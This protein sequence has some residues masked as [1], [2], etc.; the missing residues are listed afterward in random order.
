MKERFDL[1]CLP[2]SG[3]HGAS[4]RYRLFQYLPFLDEAGMKYLVHLPQDKPGRGWRRLAAAWNERSHVDRLALLSRAILLQ[5]RLPPDSWVVKIANGKPLIFDFDDAIFTSPKSDWSGWTRR[6]TEKRLRT[7]LEHAQTVIAGNRYLAEYA[8][9]F[10]SNVLILPTVVDHRKYPARAHGEKK[11]ITIGWIGHSVNHPYLAAIM[12]LL[13]K[14]AGRQ[15]IRLLVVSDRDFAS[16]EVPIEN[17][18]WSEQTEIPDILTMDIGIMPMPDDAWSR[19]KCGF[20]AIQYMAAGVP[21]VCSAVGANLD[22]VR[23]EQDGYCVRSPSEWLDALEQL[24]SDA[25]LRQR[26]GAAGRQRVATSFSLMVTAPSFLQ[27]IRSHL[28]QI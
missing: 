12:P 3:P 28:C 19:G 9:Q 6:R 20:K 5:K 7:I 24:C 21:V 11:E 1:L 18:R 8:R 27:V 16:T 13:G 10:A 26:L 22:I 2:I 17:R 15:R 4:S 14:L 23:H 25:A